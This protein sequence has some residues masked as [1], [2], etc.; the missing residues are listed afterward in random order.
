MSHQRGR[1]DE[2]VT[3]LCM[4]LP[5]NPQ[6]IDSVHA[7]WRS[8]LSLKRLN[9]HVSKVKV[10]DSDFHIFPVCS[11]SLSR[12]ISLFLSINLS[13]PLSLPSQQDLD[14]LQIH[15]EEVRFFDLFGYSEE[16]GGWLCFMCNN[17]EK[18]TGKGLAPAG[19]HTKYC[20]RIERN[21]SSL[22]YLAL[23]LENIL[24]CF[25]FF[26]FCIYLQAF[27]FFYEKQTQT[28]KACSWSSS[29]E[30]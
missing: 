5:I 21:A 9:D 19:K 7:S 12:S 2:T 16:E 17:P 25:L 11:L 4:H 6:V 1:E 8:S 13:V 15:L 14:S 20:R 30:M 27:I 10:T 22:A 18:A 28:C 3:G 26:F 23:R 29:T 24:F